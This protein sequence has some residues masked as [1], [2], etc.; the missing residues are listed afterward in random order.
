MELKTSEMLTRLSEQERSKIEGRLAELNGKS[1]Q[2]KI[3]QQ[4]VSAR[5]HQLRQQRDQAFKMRNSAALLMIFE[6]SVH[7]QQSELNHIKAR[8]CMLE[9]RRESILQSLAEAQHKHHAFEIVHNKEAR[10]Q[11]RRA[12]NHAQRQLDDLTASRTSMASA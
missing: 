12:N 11:S 8:L 2:L 10:N 9:E 3:R 4:S 6:A 5:I 1:Y 7:E